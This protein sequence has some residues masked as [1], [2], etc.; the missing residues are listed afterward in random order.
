MVAGV[1]MRKA[2]L[3]CTRASILEEGNG[4]IMCEWHVHGT[5]AHIEERTSNK[6]HEQTPL[7]D[8]CLIRCTYH[9]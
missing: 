1:P 6:H 9:S 4:F 7:N 3:K 5:Q 8:P 2:G